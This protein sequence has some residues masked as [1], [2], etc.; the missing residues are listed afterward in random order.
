V[1]ERIDELIRE[2]AQAIREEKPSGSCMD[3]H[4]RAAVNA[5]TET[6]KRIAQR[7]GLNAN[8][9]EK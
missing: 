5:P 2:L 6:T 9:E 3:D 8:E 1:N 7:L 4:L